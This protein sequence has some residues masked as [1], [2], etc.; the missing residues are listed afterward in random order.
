M[1]KILKSE[2]KLF[3]DNFYNNDKKE[4]IIFLSSIILLTI[5]W[6][7]INPRFFN[8][9]FKDYFQND[10][11][12]VHL[13]PFAYWFLVDSIL[14]FLIPALLIKSV[15][16]EK[17]SNFGICFGQKK[18]AL[19]LTTSSIIFVLP[20]ILFTSTANS[21]TKY[22]PLMQEITNSN[23]YIFFVYEILFIIFIFS[24]EFIFRGYIL[25]GLE[26]KFGFYAIFIQMI[27]F[28]ILHNGKPFFETFASIFGGIFLGYLALRT[29]SA[30][31]GF[32]I[33]TF[34]LVTLD[35]LAYLKS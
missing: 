10:N 28:V 27:P 21:F 17:L 20:I 25:F 13:L 26:K 2:F 8:Y 11:I 3:L 5:S 9:S 16:K 31:Y 4:I 19:V 15:F 34:I 24:W 1:W 23:L 12:I 18:I 30:Y 35:I 33:H 14:L 32:F 6:Y 7:F 22:F 29:R